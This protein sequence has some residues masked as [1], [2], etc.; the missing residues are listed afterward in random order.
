MNL[1]YRTILKN[2]SVL[3]VSQLY[4]WGLAILTTLF[5]PRYLGATGV[6][7]L[8]LAASVWAIVSTLAAFGMDTLLTKEVARDPSRMAELI[9]NSALARAIFFV[10]GFGAVILYSYWANY[11]SLTILVILIIGLSSFLGQMSACFQASIYGLERMEYISF[12]QIVERTLGTLL[13]IGLLLLGFGVIP[14]AVLSVPVSLIGLLILFITTKRLQR[15]N[16]K[17][18]Y[19][20]TLWMLKAS[21]PFLLFSGFIVIYG[22]IDTIII[23]LLVNEQGVGW[24]GVTDRLYGTF[25]FVPSIFISTVYPTLSRMYDSE[26]HNLPNLIRRSF[27]L[28]IMVAIPIGLGLSL[29]ANPLVIL[30][31]GSEFANSGPILTVRGIVLIF[32]YLNMLFGIFLISIDRQKEW[33]IVMGVATFLS[34]P[35]DLLLVPLS[36]TLFSNGPMGGAFSYMIT[37]L[38]M[39]LAALFLL[40]KGTLTRSNAW[41]ATRV[42]LAGLAMVVVTWWSR[43]LIIALPILMGAASYLAFLILFR[44]IKKEDWD[45]IRMMSTKMF[46]KL[47]GRIAQPVHSGQE[48]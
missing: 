26:T 7:Q 13:T 33:V 19:Q 41:Y 14:V 24:Y 48:G 18:N 39:F 15:L 4:T 21:F 5:L 10:F 12:A 34:I 1:T 44:V 16:L 35:L 30:L 43:N 25:L 32:T 11:S 28:M 36:E 29:I 45:L 23:S 27:E 3:M 40:P 9:A 6:G 31:F 47:T 22:Q 46:H 2:A 42:S 38:G 20:M 17:F 37:E 8:H